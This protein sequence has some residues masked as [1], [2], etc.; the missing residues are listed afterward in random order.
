MS[1]PDSTLPAARYLVSLP[2]H[3]VNQ[4]PEPKAVCVVEVV[5]VQLGGR[6]PEPEFASDAE[7]D[8]LEAVF[9][10]AVGALMVPPRAAV[11]HALVYFEH[12]VMPRL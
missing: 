4:P 8:G 10:V 9:T 3:K 6:S 7:Q 12:E 5:H 2:D 11:F 1:P